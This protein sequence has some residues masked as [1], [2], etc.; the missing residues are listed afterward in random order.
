[1]PSKQTLALF[2]RAAGN[3]YQNLVR[4]DCRTAALRHGFILHDHDAQ[5]DAGKQVQQIQECLRAPP[6]SRPQAILVCPVEESALQGPAREAARLGMAWV[7]L[8][9]ECAYLAE[10]RREFV[11]TALFSVH[12]DQGQ[13]GRIQADQLQIL[14][15]RGGEVAYIRGPLRTTSANLRAESFRASLSGSSIHI[16][17]LSGEWSVEGGRQA[18]KSWLALPG[19]PKPEHCA[20]SA[21]NDSMAYGA[22]LAIV[23]AAL[24]SREIGLSKIPILGC[25]GVPNFGH[26]FVVDGILTATIVIP[27]PARRA[28]DT[29]ASVL[30]GA[31]PPATDIC[32]AVSSLPE[33]EVLSS[34]LELPRR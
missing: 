13:I 8:Q 6:T 18:V 31:P 12:P 15:P 30:A 14:L 5:N 16:T 3:E 29:L 17:S 21:Q 28:V 11:R 10:L 34:G 33:L 2:F 23:E 24:G 1:V 32:L 26:R 22:H 4:E 20:I 19:R 9:R 25:D 7:A 27:C